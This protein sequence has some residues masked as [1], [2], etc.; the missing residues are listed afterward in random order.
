MTLWTQLSLVL[1]GVFLTFVVRWIWT[2]V[3][4]QTE[5]H[6]Q[7]LDNRRSKQLHFDFYDRND[8]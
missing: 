2:L 1:C 7:R 4:Y 3:L 8:T 5:V 6:R